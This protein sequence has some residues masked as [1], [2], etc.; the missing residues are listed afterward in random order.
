MKLE[1]IKKILES[2]RRVFREFIRGDSNTIKIG[3]LSLES[4]SYERHNSSVH[5]VFKINE[6]EGRF[7]Q[8]VGHYDSWEGTDFEYAEVEE[9]RPKQRTIT[10]YETV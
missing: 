3:E 5:S 7:F 4:V 6:L 1:Q 10:V 2:E 9:V 8:V